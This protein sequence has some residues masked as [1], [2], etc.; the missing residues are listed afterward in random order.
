VWGGISGLFWFAF[1]WWLRMWNIFRC[2]SATRYSSV[3][4]SLF[5]YVPHFLMGLFDFLQYSLLISLYIL[6]VS[7][8]LDL[9]LLKIHFQCVGDLFVLLALSSALK[10]LCNFMRSHLSILDLTAQAIDTLFRNFPLRPYLRG[11]PPLSP[12]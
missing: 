2:F 5:S 3:E 4:I 8:L 12:L 11:F 1:P 9:G 10:E 6:D 7:P